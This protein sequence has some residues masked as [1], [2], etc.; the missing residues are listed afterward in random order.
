[1]ATTDARKF[2]W[3]STSRP[4]KANAASPIS[5]LFFVFWQK[6]KK[7]AGLYFISLEK[8]NMK[9]MRCG[10]RPFDREDPRTAGVIDDELVG[11]G[12]GSGAVFRRI[13]YIDP[14]TGTR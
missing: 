11:P 13:T 4:C 7:T 8:S 2:R 1:M 10:H 9:L 5:G 6:A 14:V 12:G 3:I